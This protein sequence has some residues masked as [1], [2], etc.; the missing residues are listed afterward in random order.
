M[1]GRIL[2]GI[3]GFYTVLDGQG[4]LWTCKA[5]GRFRKQGISP[6]PGDL[7][8]IETDDEAGGYILDILPRKNRLIRPAVA[9]IDR[10][11]IVL[12]ASVPR[13][14]PLLIDKLLIQSELAG[15]APALIENKQDEAEGGRISQQYVPAGYPVIC[16]SAFSGDGLDGLK[17]LISDSTCCLA[18]Q[19]AVGKSSLLNALLPELHASVGGLS[20]KTDRGRHTT[21][22]AQLCQAF[23]G[24]VVDTPGF[25]LLDMSAIE[26][27]ELWRCYPEMRAVQGECRF[28]ECL[29]ISEPDCAVK[30][31]ITAGGM[32][33]D[34]YERYKQLVQELI[35][36]RR[37]RY[38]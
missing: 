10:L 12:S 28:S 22:H 16:T 11:L 18:G 35:E 9:N 15:I 8:E 3:G 26:P 21:R 6:L 25:S 1:Q 24:F 29:H 14:D 7:V 19:S 27:C 34:R 36:M 31:C 4:R 30:E 33:L 23:G 2:K 20:E 37:H 32:D 38:D 17:A 13:P 5:R